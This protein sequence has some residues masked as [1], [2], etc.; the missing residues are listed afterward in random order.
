MSGRS[1]VE[2]AMADVDWVIHC[3][4]ALPLYPPSDIWTTNVHGTRLVLEIAAQRRVRRIVHISSTSVYGIP[5]HHP[6]LE[7]DP[8]SGVGPY[9]RAKVAAEA[10]VAGFRAAGGSATV[11]RPKSFVGPERLGVFAL[12]YD[13]ARTGHG[14]PVLGSGDNRYQLLDVEDLCRAIVLAAEAEPDIANDN[15][16][17]GARVF[18]TMRRDYQDVL[19]YAGHGGRIKSLPAIPAIW[20]LRLLD[21]LNLSPVYAWVYE[22]AGKDSFVS[23]EKAERLLGFEPQF[24]NSEALIRNYRWYLDNYSTFEGKSGVSHRVPWRQGVLGA[25]K[26]VF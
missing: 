14:F 22:T 23:T 6:L 18:T 26:L 11:L 8:V 7:S 25:A 20:T 4:A 3:A 1:D 19:D 2:A 13:W 9:G 10:A 17:I 12:F 15:F 24:S 5:D 21:R 16:N